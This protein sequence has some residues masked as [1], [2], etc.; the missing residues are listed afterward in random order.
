M[1]IGAGIDKPNQGNDGRRWEATVKRDW[2]HSTFIAEPTAV[3]N[4]L[5]SDARKV[6]L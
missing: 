5:E 4:A 6:E 2:T 1:L 3:W